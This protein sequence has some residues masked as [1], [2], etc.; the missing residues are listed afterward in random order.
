LGGTGELVHVQAGY[1]KSAAVIDKRKTLLEICA[2]NEA[3]AVVQ[4]WAETFNAGEPDAVAALYAPDATIWGTL[5]Q[6]LTT[7]LT[8]ITTYFAEAARA[9]LKVKLGEH[10]LSPLSQISAVDAGEYEFT[11]T[12]DAQ[13]A[14]LPARYSF[15][16][17][18]Q[19]GV[20]MI[21]HQHSSFL[22]KPI[23]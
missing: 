16:L 6:K 2:M 7:G 11:R 22:P 20:W 12:V 5:G 9:G 3:Y 1:H 15:V 18:K 4:R 8:D 17:V 19:S 21:A 10:V 13:T 23:G 14:L